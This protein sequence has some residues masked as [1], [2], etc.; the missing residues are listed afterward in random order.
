MQILR[1]VLWLTIFSTSAFAWEGLDYYMYFGTT[2]EGIT[3][4]WSPGDGAQ[5]YQIRGYHKEHKVYVDFG[6]TEN[7][8]YT[9]V[10]PRSG[11][12]IFEVR[13]LKQI[14]TGGITYAMSEWVQS[15]DPSVSTVDG[16]HRG[17]WVYGCVAPPGNLFF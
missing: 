14:G 10:L 3:A 2:D 4:A 1:V 12:Y 8:E 17:W 11:H 16:N 13:S 7:C 5:K 9:V 6:I 15:I